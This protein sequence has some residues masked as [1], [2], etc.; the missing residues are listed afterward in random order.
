MKRDYKIVWKVIK[1]RL[2]ILKRQIE[3]LLK[4]AEGKEATGA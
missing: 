1:E 4:D 2:P 3:A